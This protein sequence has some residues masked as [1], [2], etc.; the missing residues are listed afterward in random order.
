M[1]DIKKFQHTKLKTLNPE[2]RNSF[3]A[4]LKKIVAHSQQVKTFEFN[5]IRKTPNHVILK[6]MEKLLQNLDETSA[7]IDQH[8]PLFFGTYIGWTASDDDREK[9]NDFPVKVKLMRKIIAASIENKSYEIAPGARDLY[10]P[11][12]MNA[13]QLL[14]KYGIETTTTVKSAWL[15]LTAYIL[16]HGYDLQ[17]DKTLLNYLK[18]LVG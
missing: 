15:E 14:K 9:I 8:Y 11:V 4:E 1:T 7:L 10:Y 16:L 13:K 17:K 12:M 6:Q 18:E 3:Q 2:Q 5:K